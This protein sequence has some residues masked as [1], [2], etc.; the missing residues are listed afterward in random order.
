[1]YNDPKGWWADRWFERRLRRGRNIQPVTFHGWHN[2]DL[3]DLL[4]LFPCPT[5]HRHAGLEGGAECRVAGRGPVLL[6]SRA[7]GQFGPFHDL[8]DLLPGLCSG[9]W[10][11]FSP[12]IGRISDRRPLTRRNDHPFKS[13]CHIFY[14]SVARFLPPPV[15]GWRTDQGGLPSSI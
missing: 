15:W 7:Q 14:S 9:P 2:V 4:L 10:I 5:F 3:F 13:G 1:M 8:L 12:H 6:S 11:R